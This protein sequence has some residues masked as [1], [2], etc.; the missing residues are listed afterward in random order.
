MPTISAHTLGCKVNQY[1][2]QA[3]L[4]L[5][6]AAGYRVAAPDEEADVYLVNT[7]TVTGEGDRKSLQMARRLRREHPSSRLILCGC[8]AQTRGQELLAQTGA[9]LILGTQRRHQVV[10]LLESVVSSGSPLCAVDPFPSQPPFESLSV[11]FQ[12]GHTRATL[13]IQEGCANHCTYCIIPSV[14]GPIRSRPLEGIEAEANRLSARGIRE[15]VL[16]G[17][18]LSSYGRDFS[19]RLSLTDAIRP[20][21]SAE[22]IRRIRLGSLEPNIASRA[23][24]DELRSLSKVCPQFH[25]ALQSG[26]DSVL[27]RMRRQYNTSQYLDAVA[28]LR[29]VFPSAAFTTDI[30]TGFPG[31]TEEEFRQTCDFIVTVGFARIHVFPYSPRPGTPAASMPGQLS[32]GEKEARA[33]ELIRIGKQSTE[34]FL[35]SRVGSCSELLVEESVNGC[36]EGYTPEYIRVRLPGSVPCHSGD[37]LPV[38]LQSVQDGIM[39]GIKYEGGN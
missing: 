28:N 6:L 21:Q 38:R 31:E 14:R 29:A 12:S 8:L 23:F 17:I 19:P 2:T 24:A 37:I 33:R 39:I 34:R 11:S 30:L 3:M 36:W 1:D 35:L 20:V 18:H 9:D 4:E 27:R 25:L 22:G 13:K 15:I 26:S 10:S 32:R 5:F 16:T 7:C